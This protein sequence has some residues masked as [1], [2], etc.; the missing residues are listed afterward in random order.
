[1]S[2]LNNELR[3]EHVHGQDGSFGVAGY[4]SNGRLVTLAEI[5]TTTWNFP[6]SEESRQIRDWLSGRSDVRPP[7]VQ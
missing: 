3:L 4:A 5:R 7:D 2:D 6:P 1:M